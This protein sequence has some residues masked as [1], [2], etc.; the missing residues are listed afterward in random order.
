MR[1]NL[2]SYVE[3]SWKNHIKFQRHTKE[4]KIDTTEF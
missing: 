2:T 4:H 1:I 3:L